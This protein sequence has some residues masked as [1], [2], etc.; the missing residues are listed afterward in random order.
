MSE[1][2]EFQPLNEAQLELLFSLRNVKVLRVLRQ[3][4]TAS[5]VAK[6]LELP[7]NLTHYRVNRLLGAGLLRVSDEN[8]KGRVFETVY[9]TFTVPR[10]LVG[11]LDEV[12]PRMLETLLNRVYREFF[13]EFEKL[14]LNLSTFSEAGDTVTVD[15][16]RN[17]GVLSEREHGEHVHYPPR[18]AVTSV[19]LS[20]ESYKALA[21][22]LRKHISEAKDEDGGELC[23]FAALSYRGSSVR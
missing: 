21:Q 20:K 10:A 5:S 1:T 11:E 13:S 2:N 17:L 14:A 15:L 18:A 16:E 3:P 7:V 23:T 8:G 4:D 19:K 9:K 12:L 22:T 6:T